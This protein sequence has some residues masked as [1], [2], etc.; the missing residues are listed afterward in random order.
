MNPKS[1]GT[2]RYLY[3]YLFHQAVEQ[4][5]ADTGRPIMI[6]AARKIRADVESRLQAQGLSSS[7]PD[8]RVSPVLT[9]IEDALSEGV[10]GYRPVFPE[11]SPESPAYQRMLSEFTDMIGSTR[12]GT[13]RQN[14]RMGGR[15]PVSP[16]DERWATRATVK[17]AGSTL[18]Y[19]LGDDVE[20]LGAGEAVRMSRVIHP[21]LRLWAE[22][23]EGAPADAGHALTVDDLSGMTEL[24][25][26]MTAE[27]YED[28]KGWVSQAA[29]TSSGQYDRSRF[30][31]AEAVS[32]AAAILDSLREQGVPYTVVRDREPGQIAARVEGTKISVRLT[33]TREKESFVGRVYDDGMSIYFSTNVKQEDHRTAPYTPTAEEAVLLLRVA[34]GLPVERTDGNGEAGRRGTHPEPVWDSATRRR[35]MRDVQDSYYDREGRAHM[36][37]LGDTPDGKGKVL[38]RR[39]AKARTAAARYFGRPEA[40][41]QF[42]ADAVGSARE[43]ISEALDV[44]RLVAEAAAH[45]GDEE[46]YY[47][48][49]SG[50]TEIAAVQRAYWDVLTGRADTLLRP[51]ATPEDYEESTSILAEL[52]M[53]PEQR[54]A[55][56]DMLAG[57]LAYTG[58]PEER[59]RAH[60]AEVADGMVGTLEPRELVAEDGTHLIKR[61][62]PSR[63]ARYMTSERGAWGNTADIVAALRA[64]EIDPEE[65]LGEGYGARQIKDRLVSFDPA[66]ARALEDLE[67]GV[68]RRTME[69]V[70]DSLER[71]GAEVSSLLIDGSGVI[72]WEAVR[73]DRNGERLLGGNKEP[74]TL[75]GQIGQVFEQGP[76]GEVVTSFASGEN[77]LLVPGY[78]ARIAAQRPGEDLSV[79]ERT[80]LRGYEQ[81]MAEQARY[82]VANDL[83]V[84]RTETGEPTS[85]N[86]VYRRLYEDR[87][88][89]DFLERA[90]EQGLDRGWAEAVVSTMARRVRYP[91]EMSDTSYQAW[92]LSRSNE[93]SDPSDDNQSSAIVLSGGRDMAIL[94][95]EG[96]GYF[97]PDM[98]NA[99]RMGTTRYLV[100]GASVDPATGRI[101]P[102]AEPGDRAPLMK[103]PDTA[104]MEYNS[105][106]R[107]QM[108]SS[109]L[110][111]ATSV[112]APE[113]VVMSDVLKGWT[114]DDGR[115][116]SKDYAERNKM[117]AK[118]GTLRPLVVGDK[119]SD[120]HGNKGV[121]GLVIDPAM[122]LKEAREQGIEDAVLLFRNNPGLSVVMSPFSGVSRFNGGTAREMMQ[123][124][125][126]AV[127]PDGT[128]VPGGMGE[129]R[130]VITNKDVE[131][132]TRVYDEDAIS[133]G[134]G[135]RASA[136][137]AW[138]LQALGADRVLA[139]F[140]GPNGSALA[141]LREYL[142]T[143]GLDLDQDGT[144][145][146]GQAEAVAERRLI[147]QPDLVLT[148]TGTLNTSAMR[149]GF[150][151]LIGDRGGDM[152]I[153]FPLTLP[154]GERT[155]ETGRGTWRLP[156]LSS[157]LR[158]GQ[159]MEDGTTAA[160][161]Y[162]NQYLAV[163]EQACGYRYAVEQLETGDLTPSRRADLEKRMAA[164]PGRAQSAFDTITK[165]IKDRQFSGKRNIFKEGV[166]SSRLPNSATAVWTADPRLDIDELGMSP[167]LAEGLGVEDGEH[168]LV[169][170]DPV[171][172]DGGVRYLKA[173][174]DERLTG[175]SIH[176]AMDK[177]FDG[178]FDGDSVAV[179]RLTSEGARQ[180]ALERLTVEAN[181]VDTG[182][183]ETVELDGDRMDL[184]PL[185]MQDSLDTKVS[186]HF[187]PSL[188]E[189]FA[190]L[191]LRAN[192]VHYDLEE[193]DIRRH[194]ALAQGRALVRELSD[195]Y[196][197]A[198]SPDK[199]SVAL[200]FDGVESHMRSMVEA[201]VET[202]AKGSMG[203]M[204]TYARYLGADPET[205]ED[206]GAPQHE[207][208]D[209]EGVQVAVT[210]KT[211][212]GV[213]GA[214]AQRGVKALRNDA[215]KA[216][217]EL[218]YPVTQSQLQAKHDPVE[219]MV[220]RDLLHGATR[221]HWRGRRVVRENGAWEALRDERGGHVQATPEEWREQFAAI[222]SGEGGLNVDI[223]DEHV[224][225]VTE[226]LTDPATGR[227]VD[228]EDP[229]NQ[230]PGRG[231]TL[232]RLAYG[233]T[234]D[235]VLAAASQ[236]ERLFS[237]RQDLAFAPY[238]LRGNL[239]E[240]EAYE[241]RQERA[242]DPTRP[243]P[244]PELERIAVKDVLAEADPSAKAR[245]AN[246]RTGRARA[247]RAGRYQAPAEQQPEANAPGDNDY[248]G[249]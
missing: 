119:D 199:G 7:D 37:V 86:G 246:R 230:G 95:E 165:G 156:V 100:E 116:V 186:Q 196:H 139:E 59:V 235:D 131:A 211:A 10:K 166:M 151:G 20:Q 215:I 109:M 55:T 121:I 29:R 177:S 152:E 247:V 213:A 122:D 76:L 190:R 77:Y 118:D 84:M 244:G 220:K 103:H 242:A 228:I 13:S 31:S 189:R 54:D 27:E 239:R 71:G 48:E 1:P 225:T 113:K 234:F 233:G 52:D 56:H 143:M 53:G 26:R 159:E 193:G 115:V 16:Y 142:V 182:H 164:A 5:K 161:D 129:M 229:T 98:T 168:V 17:N 198:L 218:T 51:G 153:P 4:A 15:L 181:L 106:D 227:I 70:R 60:A 205:F 120:L 67:D 163:Y 99:A 105:W 171:L 43:N 75:R 214:F 24:M 82:Q 249:S 204:A 149:R 124:A 104:F 9:A 94:S 87:R 111:H 93:G 180:Q 160:H 185:A 207:R 206:L 224:R 47:P 141:N 210:V 232:D 3:E 127:M 33:D 36:M 209:D 123:N 150:G 28:V 223:G 145:R 216:V 222:Y 66:T 46:P 23:P 72:S 110:L 136:Q 162:T 212:V 144:L 146:V 73:L 147:E 169:W 201:C 135:R 219:A 69:V 221:A 61:F 132:G 78:E 217:T 90:A 91:N 114:A 192:D 130:F 85:L 208:Q 32:R 175:V 42:L 19:V 138:G 74:E 176:P 38:I 137:L 101:T 183:T 187:D 158:T 195:Y 8:L 237:G 34:Q 154:S 22:T 30:M 18:L 238:S 140:Y 102:S 25:G 155:A 172:R 107:R 231:C 79:E 63:V 243:V 108:I 21:E 128:V 240:L 81:V 125:S 97:D 236:G 167:A 241:R 68:Q 194:E 89:A 179:V 157:H 64:A 188:K 44:D 88:P 203:K 45:A 174:V 50:D 112:T 58:T 178:D 39:S 126:D 41:E 83:M 117:L 148:Q 40:A 200:R 57:H 226:A 11:R 245:G 6:S 191:T 62:D 133:L 12:N 96:D 197:E 65:L 248:F 202:G 14:G 92:A 184:Y 134:R 80:L 2:R 173:K 35:V 170:R 49:L